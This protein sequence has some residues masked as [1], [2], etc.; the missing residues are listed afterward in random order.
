MTDDH[1]HRGDDVHSVE[2]AMKD[3]NGGWQPIETAPNFT[4]VM[5][6][7]PCKDWPCSDCTHWLA[8]ADGCGDW[9]DQDDC[10]VVRAP[11]HWM[12]LPAAPTEG[13]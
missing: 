4:W 9:V 2:A 13:E 10:L 1:T 7:E 3:A 8:R 11:T 6:F 12:P 5:L